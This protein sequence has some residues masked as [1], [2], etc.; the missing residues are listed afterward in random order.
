MGIVLGIVLVAVGA[1]LSFAVR[2][3][4]D[5]VDLRLIGYIMMGAG[6]LAIILGLITN[7]QRTNTS[8]REVVDRREDRTDRLRD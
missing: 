7:A 6:G 3:Q 1:V 4:W 8:H 2:D 5:V